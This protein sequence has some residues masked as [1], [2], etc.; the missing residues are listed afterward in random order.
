MKK[1]FMLL[2][3]LLISFAAKAHRFNLNMTYSE[4]I[5][6]GYKNCSKA[7][8][9]EIYN[10]E[11]TAAIKLNKI[12]RNWPLAS[13]AEVRHDYVIKEKR[14]W[15][16]ADPEVKVYMSYWQEMGETFEEM[17]DK[18]HE[19]TFECKSQ[20]EKR[21]QNNEVFAYVLF[22]FNY[23]KPVIHICPAFYGKSQESQAGTLL[24]ELSHYSSSTEDIA[25]DWINGKDVD[26]KRASKDAYHI[27]NFANEDVTQVLKRMVWNS[28]WPKG[29]KH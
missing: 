20:R 1:S 18:F 13:L 16:K 29:K 26:L 14:V 4:G 19:V 22:Y 24:H 7:Q 8:E 21:C 11:K 5:G 27:E 9:K 10:A 28:V 12:I 17:R 3:L 6:Y 2:G 15:K 23:A 25:L